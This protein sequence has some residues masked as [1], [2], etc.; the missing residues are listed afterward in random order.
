VY[1]CI[2]NALTDKRL[3]QAVADGNRRVGDVYAACGCRAQCG[4]CA[5]AIVR[6]VRDHMPQPNEEPLTAPA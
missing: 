3:A 1:I 5:Q 4:K 2:C 6:L